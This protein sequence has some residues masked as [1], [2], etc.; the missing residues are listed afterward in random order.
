MRAVHEEF[1][2]IEPRD[3]GGR[4]PAVLCPA[5]HV[6]GPERAHRKRHLSGDAQRLA[7]RGEHADGFAA[8]DECGDLPR[9]RIHDVLAVV[10]DQQHLAPAEVGREGFA[11]RAARFLAHAQRVGHGI[12]QAGILF[13]GGQLDQPDPVR[14]IVH[15]LASDLDGEPGFS[16]SAGAEEGEDAGLPEQILDLLQ[17]AGPADETG[18]CDGE[19]VGQVLLRAERWKRNRQAARLDLEDPLD[20]VQIPQ[21]EIAE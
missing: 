5:P 7:A 19:V 1:H 2:G 4:H 16:G 14:K 13:E 3:I 18:L 8:G 17:L 11:Q 6:E 10:E 20:A 9:N 21:A 12:R 15:Q